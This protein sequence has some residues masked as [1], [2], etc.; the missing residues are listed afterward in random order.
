MRQ[1]QPRGL[2]ASR[3]PPAGASASGVR[4]LAMASSTARR[5]GA[6]RRITACGTP[7]PNQSASLESCAKRQSA[8]L[9][10]TAPQ[11]EERERCGMK[12]PMSPGVAPKRSSH[13]ALVAI[14][15]LLLATPSS[16]ATLPMLRGASLLS[17]SA[18]TG[19]S[20]PTASTAPLASRRLGGAL[21]TRAVLR[22]RCRTGSAPAPEAAGA[23][24][25]AR[26][27][28]DGAPAGMGAEL[29]PGGVGAEGASPEG[30][31]EDG[32]TAEA[33]EK[34]PIAGA[35]EEV[36]IA[37]AAEKVPTAGAANDVPLAGAAELVPTAGAADDVPLAEAAELVPTAG[38]AEAVLPAP[39]SPAPPAR[40]AP[41][42][43]A[44]PAA[45]AASA[46][47]ARLRSVARI[48]RRLCSIERQGRP[49]SRA[50]G[51]TALPST[52]AAKAGRC[53]CG[54]CA[55]SGAERLRRC[56]PTLCAV[57][58]AAHQSCA[59]PR[60]SANAHMRPKMATAAAASSAA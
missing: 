4:S 53:R 33:A 29:A 58:C 59:M 36:T 41:P 55:A 57:A 44:P 51:S 50:K 27:A 7:Q 13:C 26:G 56:L 18:S 10:T 23:P 52:S 42:A 5:S 32:P 38:A 2:Q 49:S 1:V 60:S 37:E 21:V 8:A 46:A 14:R 31:A 16:T 40:P 22:T 3:T 28:A 30:A 15:R 20:S 45:P 11:M 6:G 17:D 34:V 43:A 54:S 48:A 19:I 47:M 12:G 35:A 25:E 24:A 9:T 39:A